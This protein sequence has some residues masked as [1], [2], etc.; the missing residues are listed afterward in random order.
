LFKF[1]KPITPFTSFNKKD[2]TTTT[3]GEKS[4]EQPKY[5]FNNFN[6]SSFG[7]NKPLFSINNKKDDTTVSGSEKSP[8]KSKPL[9]SFNNNLGKKD[10]TVVGS[11]K[12]PSLFSLPTF[13][14]SPTTFG[15]SNDKDKTD[16]T[17]TGGFK[18]NSNL[19]FNTESFGKPLP[20]IDSTITF[21]IPIFG[22]NPAP[23]VEPVTNN[24]YVTNEESDV[25]IEK[26]AEPIPT[27]EEDEIVLFE[28]KAKLYRFENT[29]IT[30]AQGN[31]K[32]NKNK[33]IN[34]CRLLMRKEGGLTL[35]L[36]ALIFPKMTLTKQGDKA[37]IFPIVE[38][39]I[40]NET[41][42][43]KLVQYLCR[44]TTVAD[45]ENFYSKL[46]ECINSN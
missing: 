45:T 35:A 27:G 34:K 28:S 25:N 9:F 3:G 5:S 18:F 36:N 40:E 12:T 32:I 26:P 30:F 39:E 19:S 31:L 29:W 8:E 22:Q 13:N 38:S 44:F 33:N 10:D 24:F 20:G 11:E 46:S 1:D 14:F 41:S 6:N 2:D 15:S 23:P 42:K 16:I 37:I 43:T 17:T 7:S 4:P 21:K